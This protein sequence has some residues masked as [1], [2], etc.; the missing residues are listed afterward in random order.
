M[1]NTN[2]YECEFICDRLVEHVENDDGLTVGIITP[3]T[4]QQK[5]ISTMLRKHPMYDDFNK[6]LQLKI[7]T[8][9]SCQGEERDI[10]Y[11]SMVGTEEDDRLG[12]VFPSSLKIN[13]DVEEKL[14]LQRLNV[15]FSRSKECI[16]F[17]LSKTI[18]NYHGSV[19]TALMHYNKELEKAK[20]LPEKEDLDPNSPMELKVLNWIKNSDFYTSNADKIEIKAQFPIGEYLKQINPFYRHPNYRCDF[21][22]TYADEKGDVKNIIIEYDGFKEHFVDRENIN[23]FNYQYYYKENDIEREKII[24]GYGYKFLRLNRFNLGKYPEKTIS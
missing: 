1:T 18:E 12:Y 23:E 11:Y 6:K 17:V 15:G 13:D 8:F 7:M 21:L 4:N 20:N 2:E 22:F 5:F 10:I 19:G 3:F 24:E 9:D 16:H 14:R